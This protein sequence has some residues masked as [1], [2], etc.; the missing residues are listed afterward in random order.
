MENADLVFAELRKRKQ[1]IH[2]LLVNVRELAD[3]L[4][5]LVQ[6]NQ[7]IGE[8][9]L[10]QL[11]EVLTF[12]KAREDKLQTLLHEPR[13]L[14]EHPRQHRRHRPLVRRLPAQPRQHRQPQ[15]VHSREEAERMTAPSK[16]LLAGV[17]AGLVLLA[18]LVVIQGG[19]G[20]HA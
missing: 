11:D 13:P 9:T 17:V 3:D 6:D 4:R 12:L 8:P 14:R 2:D 16:R 7:A 1:A 20:H 19:S 15:R 5:G 10:D 18:M